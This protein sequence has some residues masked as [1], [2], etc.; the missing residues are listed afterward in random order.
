MGSQWDGLLS[1]LRRYNHLL[2]REEGRYPK[3][4]RTTPEKAEEFFRKVHLEMKNLTGGAVPHPELRFSPYHR[5]LEKSILIFF[6][7]IV[8]VAGLLFYMVLL[9]HSAGLITRCEAVPLLLFIGSLL[10]IPVP[11]YRRTRIN[12]E[13]SCCYMRI[14]GGRIVMGDMREGMFLSFCAHE[15]AHHFL[16]EKGKE[17]GLWSEG[18]ARM[19][20]LR[21]SEVLS[22]VYRV[23]ALTPTLSLLVGEL[24]EALILTKGERQLPHWVKRVRS[25]FHTSGL[26]RWI[27]GEPGHSKGEL[28]KHALGTAILALTVEAKGDEVFKSPFIGHNP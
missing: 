23:D 26:A 24:K 6:F 4:S 11:V 3:G 14:G 10:Y 19:A 9:A 16:R 22:K 28:L 1:L 15:M 25:P 12:M 5:R 18:W 17:G 20:Q 2:K 21:V 27:K 13:H 7:T 8:C